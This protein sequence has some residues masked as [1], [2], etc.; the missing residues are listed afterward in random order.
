MHLSEVVHVFR[1][2]YVLLCHDEPEQFVL[3]ELESSE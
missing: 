1:G 3:N 2:I